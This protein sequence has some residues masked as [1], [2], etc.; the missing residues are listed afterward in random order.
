M[1]SER[2]EMREAQNAIL[3]L[4]VGSNRTGVVGEK[5]ADNRSI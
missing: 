4:G 2:R 1:L 3:G 5:Q